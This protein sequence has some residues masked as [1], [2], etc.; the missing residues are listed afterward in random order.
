MPKSEYVSNLLA[1]DEEV[2]VIIVKAKPKF[3]NQV[4]P[5]A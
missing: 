1:Q 2:E 5:T 4:I 3:P